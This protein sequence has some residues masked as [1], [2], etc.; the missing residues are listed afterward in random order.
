MFL[1]L[2]SSRRPGWRSKR[3]LAGSSSTNAATRPQDRQASLTRR[4]RT[5]HWAASMDGKPRAR[6]FIPG[7]LRASQP[8][9]TFS[10]Y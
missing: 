8:G 7:R 1:D 2:T 3:V 6:P 4:A 5:L 9:L 10:G